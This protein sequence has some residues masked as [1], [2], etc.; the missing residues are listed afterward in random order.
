MQSSQDRILDALAAAITARGFDPVKNAEWANT[1]HLLAMRGLAVNVAIAFDF[2][3]L[4]FG[5]HVAPLHTTMDGTFEDSPPRY[6]FANNKLSWHVL[7]YTDAPRITEMLALLDVVLLAEACMYADGRTPPNDEDGVVHFP[8]GDDGDY[9][10][11]NVTDEGVIMDAWAAVPDFKPGA[12]SHVHAGTS[13][14][15]AEDLFDQLAAPPH[16]SADDPQILDTWKYEVA[17]GDTTLG[18]AQWLQGTE[19]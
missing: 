5:L 7:D 6:R 10:T 4:T 14:T 16:P 1:G 8:I 19:A 15:M 11:V 3:P 12:D 17:N 18:F 13:A 9:L 2:Q